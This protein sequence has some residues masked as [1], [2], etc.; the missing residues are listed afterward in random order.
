MTGIQLY[1]ELGT[2]ESFCDRSMNVHFFIWVECAGSFDNGLLSLLLL[3][4]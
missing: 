2:W 1:V 3:L 4:P